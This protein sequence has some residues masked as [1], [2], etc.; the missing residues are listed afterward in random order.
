MRRNV[1]VAGYRI[2]RRGCIC[3]ALE[4]GLP[5]AQRS[6]RARRWVGAP[7]LGIQQINQKTIHEHG[8]SGWKSKMVHPLQA[9][10][11]VAPR[12]PPSADRIDVLQF[13]PLTFRRPIML[14]RSPV[15][16]LL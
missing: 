6:I 7:T 9:V 4:A 16:L 3:R 12:S 1:V 10:L 13:S 8:V 5:D 11:I 15:D 14:E 2:E